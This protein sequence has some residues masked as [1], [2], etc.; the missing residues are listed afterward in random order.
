[1]PRRTTKLTAAGLSVL[2]V[3]FGVVGFACDQATYSSGYQRD[4]PVNS[5]DVGVPDAPG[6]GVG[7]PDVGTCPPNACGGCGPLDMDPGRPCGECDAGVVVCEGRDRVLCEQA[8]DLVRNACGGCDAL[9]N[10]PGALCGTCNSGTWRCDDTGSLRCLGDTGPGARN[11]CGGCATLDERAG[12]SCGTCDT[13]AWACET[14]ERLACRGDRGGRALNQCGGC[15]S[16][17]EQPGQSCGTCGSGAYGCAGPDSV[18]CE[19]DQGRDALNAC[20]GCR[21]LE[22]APGTPCGHCQSGTWACSSP[23]AV[24]CEQQAPCDCQ[25]DR[26]EPNDDEADAPLVMPG[27]LTATHC[28]ED[29]DWY[30]FDVDGIGDVLDVQLRYD[31]GLVDEALPSGLYGPGNNLYRIVPSPDPAVDV[32]EGGPIPIGRQLLGRWCL[33]LDNTGEPHSVPYT[34]DISIVPAPCELQDGDDDVCDVGRLVE[35]G[36][37][38]AAEICPINDLDWYCTAADEGGAEP[39][40]SRWLDGFT[41]S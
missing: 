34:A 30:C 36:V 32:L 4:P 14:R 24:S 31:H 6:E 29:P 3:A 17:Q 22:E 33:T 16:L 1:M 7:N 28:G 25:P 20:G 27:L 13:G 41:L 18:A 26:Y 35:P 38:I 5:D 8:S 12:V 21:P 19:G 9:E 11:E 10:T 15:A 2:A 23:D 40:R 37:E 39:D